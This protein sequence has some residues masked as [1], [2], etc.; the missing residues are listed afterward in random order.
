MQIK[1]YFWKLTMWILLCHLYINFSVFAQTADIL[2]EKGQLG[3]EIEGCGNHNQ[4]Y[5]CTQVGINYYNAGEIERSRDF[6]GALC[7][8]SIGFGCAYLGLIQYNDFWEG[9]GSSIKDV[10]ITSDI[11]CQ[12]DSGLAC[13]I[14][15]GVFYLRAKAT[16]SF[17]AFE[18]SCRLGYGRGCSSFAKIRIVYGTSLIHESSVLKDL[19]VSDL[20][21]LGCIFGDLDSCEELSVEQ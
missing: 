12:L 20:V 15:G 18:K 3:Q 1:F 6:F 17:M 14:N 16:E 13:F 8:R 9:H 19:S 11:G 4:T 7:D 21:Q 5:E 2:E 10:E